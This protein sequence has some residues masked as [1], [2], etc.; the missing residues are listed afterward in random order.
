MNDSFS[1]E[2]KNELN[3]EDNNEPYVNIKNKY[4][5]FNKKNK[6]NYINSIKNQ[7]NKKI[8]KFSICTKSFKFS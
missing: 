1:E 7:N 2:S 6:F 4:I 8:N 5:N 3:Y